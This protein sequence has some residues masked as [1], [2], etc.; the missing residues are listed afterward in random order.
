M[1]NIFLNLLN[2]PSQVRV[3]TYLMV[4][5]GLSLT[6]QNLPKEWRLDDSEHILYTGNETVDGFFADSIIHEMR[7]SFSQSNY[8]TLLTSNYQ[9]HTDLMASINIDGVQIDSVG[10]RFKGATSYQMAGNTQKKSFNITLDSFIEGQEIDGY[11]TLNLNNCFDDPSFMKE[12]LYLQRARR[13]IPVAKGSY[14]HLY[15]NDVD[16]GI[17]PCIQ[18]INKKLIKEWFRHNDGVL[19][20]ADSPNGSGGGGPGGGGPSWGDGTAAMNDLGSDTTDYMNYYTLKNSAIPDPWAKLAEVC[21]II[22]DTPAAQLEEVLNDYM[23]IDRTLWTLASE[24]IFTDDDSYVFKGKMD[25]YVFR[26]EEQGRFI[27]MEYDGNSSFMDD[28]ASQWPVFYHA[29]DGDYPLISKLLAV[30]SLRQRYLAHFRTLMYESLDE[31]AM[32]A[33]IDRIDNLIDSLVQADTKKL[34]TYSAYT[35]GVNELH[36]YS[37]TRIAFLDNESELMQV[38][39]TIVMASHHTAGVEWANPTSTDSVVVT[40]LIGTEVAVGQVWLYYSNDLSGKFTKVSIAD[41]GQGNDLLAGDSIYTGIIPPMEGGSWVRY[42]IAAESNNSYGTISYFPV[43]A[44]HDVFVY[45]VTPDYAVNSPVVINEIMASNSTAIPDSAG[46]YDDWVELYNRSN[47]PV[48]L[49]GYVLTDNDQYLDKWTIPTGTILAP[50]SYL[51]IW[52]DENGAQGDYHANFKLSAS[53][54]KLVLLTADGMIADEVSFTN[55]TTDMGYARIPNGSGD[56]VMQEHTHNG[57]NE[58]NACI[59]IIDCNGVCNGSAVVDECGIC[60]GTGITT[61]YI[62]TDGDGLGE[63]E[64]TIEACTQPSGYVANADD[65]TGI[66]D[67]S[68]ANIYY[69]NGYLF[70]QNLAQNNIAIYNVLGQNCLNFNIKSQNEIVPLSKL[71]NGFYIA[72][73][74]TGKVLKF[75]FEQ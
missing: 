33:H 44:E 42:Y 19:W 61:W 41:D 20:R 35:S 18:Q 25:Y 53:G 70:T 75:S 56:F 71:N 60:N 4:M 14:V 38:A 46:E 40:T 30:P 43:G 16:W 24:I 15:L 28:L 7:I 10:V 27:P 32:D 2:H 9:S 13:H 67:L 74:N 31:A 59:G 1:K 55:L 58:F 52:A 12:V 47:E 69:A 5:L 26:D 29:N 36:D 50:D 57:N 54:E 62:D 22:N 11:S 45:L 37:A 72:K 66:E 63:I 68:G 49:S 17:Y 48:D 6:A 21:N 3:F 73:T 64:T 8:W 34:Y 39:P 23:D 65:V 51:I